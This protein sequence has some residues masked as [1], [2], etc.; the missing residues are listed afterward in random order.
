MFWRDL[1]TFTNR[2]ED[3]VL[4]EVRLF[5]GTELIGL[6]AV[7]SGLMQPPTIV[8]SMLRTICLRPLSSLTTFH[9]RPI[10]VES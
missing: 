3:F 10:V 9:I 8:T 5:I 1:W 6:M 2:S 7:R 4:H